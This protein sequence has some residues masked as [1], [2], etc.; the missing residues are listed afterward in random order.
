MINQTAS[1]TWQDTEAGRVPVSEQF[2]DPY[3][4]LKNGLAET[5][6]VFLAGNGLPDRFGG[7]FHIAELGFGTGLNLLVT[8]DAWIKAGAKGHLRFTSFEAYPMAI[9]D[10][11]AALIAFPQLTHLAEILLDK[12]HPDA[13]A[14]AVADDITLDVIIGDARETLPRWNG[15]ADAWYL[16]G[17]SPDKNPELWEPALLEH[18]AKHTAIGGTAATYS[19][20]GHVRRSLK[21]AGFDVKRIPGFGS[22]WHMAVARLRDAE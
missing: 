14:V 12:W 5:Q 3:Y 9:T 7:D 15:A 18:V 13:G 11:K 20:A 21:S 10:M 6:Y 19:A 17:F 8:W 22:K 16:D 1:L 4:S 2:D